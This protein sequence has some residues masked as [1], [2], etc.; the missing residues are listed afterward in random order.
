MKKEITSVYLPTEIKEQAKALK[1]NIS[2]AATAGVLR[3]IKKAEL[4]KEAEKKIEQELN[5]TEEY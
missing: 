5:K 3:A 2:Q 1:I 4:M